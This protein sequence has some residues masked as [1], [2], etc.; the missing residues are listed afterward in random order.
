MVSFL[1][2]LFI[3]VIGGITFLPLVALATYIYIKGETPKLKSKKSTA[4]QPPFQHEACIYKDPDNVIV[5]K[6]WIRLT[7]QYQPRMPE[8]SNSNNNNG[9]IAGI[10]SYVSNNN[11]KEKDKDNINKNGQK[12]GI[13]Y[14]VLKHGT[15]FCYENEKQAQVVMILPMQD[16]TVTLYPPKEE[17]AT[18]GSMYNR[19]SVVRLVPNALVSQLKHDVA[20][21]EEEPGVVTTLS[22][23][24]I[25][26]SP[27]RALYL[28]CIRNID[29]ED[30][31]LGLRE[32]QHMLISD[33]KNPEEAQYVMMDNTHF[34]T[35]AIEDL[36]RQVQ[37]SPS[38]RETAWIN[39]V[40]GR[41]FL[42]M[43]KTDR[44]KHF[45]EMKIRKKIDKTKRPTFLD[46][47]SVRKVDVGG[48]VPF[49]TDPK[50]L[51]LSPEGEVI[52]EAKVEYRG[53]L[54]IEIETD[55]NWSYSSRLKPIRMH[56]ILAV[57]LNQMSGRM[58]FKIKAPP[59]NR[60]W[61]AFFEMPEMDW[62]IT[63]VVADKQIKLS[64]VTNAIESRIREVMADSFVLPNMDDTSFCPSQGKGGIFGEYVKVEKRSRRE[65]AYVNDDAS[66]DENARQHSRE[67]STS[68]EKSTGGKESMIR[69][70][71]SV[72]DYMLEKPASAADV[73]KLKS[74]R[75]ESA[76]E[77]AINGGHQASHD[78]TVKSSASASSV[79]LHH[80]KLEVSQSIPAIHI[81]PLATMSST[82][83]GSV[84][85]N[86]SVKSVD[87][88][89]IAESTVSASS[90]KWSSAASNL[91]KRLKKGIT[92]NNEEG[93]EDH[94]SDTESVH[95]GKSGLL[96]KIHNILPT[97]NHNSDSINSATNGAGD[98]SNNNKTS[99][100]KN[101]L[102]QKA[103]IFIAKKAGHHEDDDEVE[104]QHLTEEKKEAY[105]ERM[106]NMRRRAEEQRK[107]SSTGSLSSNSI[108]PPP[109][110]PPLLASSKHQQ[111]HFPESPLSSTTKSLLDDDYTPSERSLPAPIVPTRC[112]RAASSVLE[113]KMPPLPPRRISTPTPPAENLVASSSGVLSPDMA[114][115]SLPDRFD[116]SP[117]SIQEEQDGP[118]P[119]SNEGES[120]I[121]PAQQVKNQVVQAEQEQQHSV[122]NEQS[123]LQQPIETVQAEEHP[124]VPVVA[125]SE[126]TEE[127]SQQQ[128]QV[129]M[130][131]KLQPPAIPN[132]PRPPL[133]TTPRPNEKPPLPNVPRPAPPTY[134][135]KAEEK[136]C[137]SSQPPPLPPPRSA[138]PPHP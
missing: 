34:D 53:G 71:P 1:G 84:E 7:N 21:K 12:K 105:A 135:Q 37:S 96:N 35:A 13:I 15:L 125:A 47:I 14:A 100:K 115:S 102:L 85:D 4:T 130:M 18:E 86:Q 88:K 112:E 77:F 90:S 124:A 138:F 29:K 33:E 49:I 101:S 69:E 129:K 132:R 111:Q 24:D 76:A 54:T 3:Y 87:Q 117:V 65:S 137:P 106:A 94:H 122:E 97:D 22:E 46:E 119:I 30:W 107:R 8:V 19:T 44:L 9:I 83:L 78:S 63:P 26:S 59:T 31:Y 110:L 98:N 11:N 55:F 20:K 61:L 108:I 39:A 51:S 50:L 56:L 66:S 42:G 45:V 60:Y 116:A 126:L 16:F 32:A 57:K 38:H 43:Y 36:I 91:R 70:S 104:Q 136:S 128:I 127:P 2:F 121:T 62:K 75:A 120:G 17:V 23:E 133:P 68:S 41:L 93:N 80:Q 40:F 82:S 73:L 118:L 113:Q 58:M 131:P 103:E 28:T 52:V 95:S 67:D 79:S 25:T 74:R 89:S 5:K 109:P 92:E 6:G 10:S 48:S 64:I 99:N 72:P 114:P 81:I 27:T 134:E 123:Q